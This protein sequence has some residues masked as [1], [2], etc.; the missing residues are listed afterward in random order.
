[1]YAIIE[2]RDNVAKSA[3]SVANKDTAVYVAVS[4]AESS[5]AI[6]SDFDREEITRLLQ[7]VGSYSDGEVTV[8]ILPINELMLLAPKA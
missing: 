7:D 6:T 3:I 4:Q 8:T 2:C 5:G 1:M